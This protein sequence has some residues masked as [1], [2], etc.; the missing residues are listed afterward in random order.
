[1]FIGR[2]KG[3]ALANIRLLLRQEAET[4]VILEVP[5]QKTALGRRTLESNGGQAEAPR[6]LLRNAKYSHLL[7]QPRWFGARSVLDAGIKGIHGALGPRQSCS[8]LSRQKL[9]GMHGDPPPF[10]EAD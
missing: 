3:G 10:S 7:S 2:G 5:G 4:F 9:Q 6:V 8:L 1:M